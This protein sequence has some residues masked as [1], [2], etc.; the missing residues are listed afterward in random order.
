VDRAR[1]I[2]LG[3]ILVWRLESYAT[4]ARNWL[5]EIKRE[6]SVEENENPGLVSFNS[7][8]HDG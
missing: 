6:L 2:Y 5:K 8:Q 1:A 3:I 4:Q 7:E